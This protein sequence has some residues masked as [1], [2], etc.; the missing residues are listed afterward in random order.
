MTNASTFGIFEPVHLHACGS[1]DPTQQKTFGLLQPHFRLSELHLCDQGKRSRAPEGNDQAIKHT[2][3]RSD[4]THKCFNRRHISNYPIGIQ[5]VC[6]EYRVQS[7]NMITCK[8]VMQSHSWTLTHPSF[9][10][11]ACNTEYMCTY[12]LYCTLSS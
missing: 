6:C 12:I 10:V 3:Y 7:T 1:L 2:F 4:P 11:I 8:Y 9:N 5:W